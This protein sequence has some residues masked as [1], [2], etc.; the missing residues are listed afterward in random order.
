MGSRSKT[1]LAYIAG[2]LDGDGSIML[3]I[4][5]RNDTT[6]GVRFMATIC[7]YQDT[8]HEIPLLWIRE[9]FGI[10][11]ISR[12][13]DG[14][15]ELR[16]NGFASVREILTQLQPYVR[17]KEAQLSALVEACTIL[18]TNT[19]SQLSERQLRK[20]VD[21]IL[22][23]RKHNYKSSQPYTKDTLLLR[24]GLTP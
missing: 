14:M 6:R 11:Y 15:T 7:L 1:D 17:F 22:I 19:V 4:K 8:R 23:I 13:K 18:E 9:F 21:L 3:Q 12:R 20:L 24:L 16:I 2:F 10:G 5:S